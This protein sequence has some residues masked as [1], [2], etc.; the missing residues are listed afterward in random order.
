MFLLLRL[1]LNVLDREPER[2][3]ESRR[4]S[5]IE[6]VREPER[7]RERA[8]E[9]HRES[10]WLSV[11]LSLWLSLSLT[12][13]L[14]FSPEC[15]QNP[16]LAHKALARLPVPLVRWSTLSWSVVGSVY[17][18]F[19][20]IYGATSFVEFVLQRISNVLPAR[21][22]RQTRLRFL[23]SVASPSST[24]VGHQRVICV[25]ECLRLA[26]CVSLTQWIRPFW[27]KYKFS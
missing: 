21:R 4:E 5:W 7:V 3:R 8:R 22:L 19:P 17:C 24:G 27:E 26:I 15:S 2:V 12:L 16:C 25:R 9:S 18:Y 10:L 14:S 11:V 6:P 1:Y 13:S 23:M 20:P